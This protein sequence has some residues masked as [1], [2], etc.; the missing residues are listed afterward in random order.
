MKRQCWRLTVPARESG[1][2]STSHARQQSSPPTGE[3][4]ECKPALHGRSSG[5]GSR[6]RE[7][8]GPEVRFG[9]VWT[10]FTVVRRVIS[11]K[12]VSGQLRDCR[13]CGSY[14]TARDPDPS[15]NRC[16][17]RQGVQITLRLA[18]A[19]TR[20]GEKAL[21]RSNPLTFKKETIMV[22]RLCATNRRRA[23]VATCLL[24]LFLVQ[25]GLSLPCSPLPVVHRRESEQL[26]PE[27]GVL[28]IHSHLARLPQQP[29]RR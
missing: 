23:V 12:L 11:A 4:V 16:P 7:A 29:S 8:G 22:A 17:V 27:R 19:S 5:S 21:K 14:R 13:L 3:A 28:E 15:F 2:L 26:V 24:L 10:L 6:V 20:E 9:E 1:D 25:A 18:I